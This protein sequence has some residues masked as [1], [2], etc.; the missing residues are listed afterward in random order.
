MSYHSFV[1]YEDFP[2]SRRIYRKFLQVFKKHIK[3]IKV[4]VINV[5]LAKGLHEQF[6]TG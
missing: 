1:S 5:F 3:S 4:H 6:P 2:H